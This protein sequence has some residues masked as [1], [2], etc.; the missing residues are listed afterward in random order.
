MRVLVSDNLSP[1]GLKILRDAGMEVD[2]RAKTTSEELLREIPNVEGLIIR[3]ATKVTD[4][5][6][7][8]G[9]RLKVIGRAGSGLDNVD[10]EA[11]TRRGV[12]VMNTPGGNTVTTAEHTIAMLLALV[13]QIPQATAS[14]KTGKWEKSK[15]VGVELYS[16][17]LG[18]IG[19]GQIGT[20]VA[21]LAQGLLMNVIAY[22][23]YL[24]DERARAM[25]VQSLPLEEVL[26]RAD[27]LSLH[28]PLTPE[29]RNLI[30][31]ETIKK[32]K[33]GIRIINCARGGIVNE[34][35]LHR[36]MVEGHVAGAAFDV[37]DQEPVDPNHPLLK[38]DSFICTPHLGAATTEAQENVAIAVAEQVV[39]YLVRGVIRNA[40][41]L[42]SV[43]AD[44]L[45]KMAPY[46]GLAEKL[47]AFA[48]QWHEGGLE[49]VTVEY[50]GE[51][52]GLSTPPLTIAVLRGLLNPILEN[53]VNYVN[54]PVVAKERGIEVRE[55]KSSEVGEYQ[56]LIILRVESAR[57]KTPRSTV[58]AGT[59][60]TRRD[61]RI[62]AMDGMDLEVI[63]E[64]Y[65]LA[66][67]NDDQPGVI[68]MLGT[69]LGQ[70]RINI[71][72][73]QLGR[74]R[75]GGRAIS[76]FSIDGE[77]PA[78]L[79]DKIRTLPNIRSVKQIRL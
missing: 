77:A 45:P 4:K 25:G 15:W 29:T 16:K 14:I 11:A 26:A 72:R 50:C 27:F 36:A 58:V 1:A 65:M 76:V 37:F 13:R 31:A 5:V 57:G 22:D 60:T 32:M 23:P 8:A 47:G 79:L 33:R 18:I 74:E 70:N 9:E 62:V 55:V 73:L 46:L 56:S 44:L 39:D 30:D 2:A 48:A 6:L 52:A 21:K 53:S 35:D 61:P 63:P 75:P 24:S 43:P 17:T 38:L 68:G 71:A 3:S 40:A 54:A 28:T 10:L 64:G 7:A 34:Q 78:A 51:A 19:L 20:H 67:E 59:L 12:V 41:N 49:R 66:L 69:L 42:P